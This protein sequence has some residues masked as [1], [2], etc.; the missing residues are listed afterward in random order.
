MVR[1]VASLAAAASAEQSTISAE[2][3]AR[4]IRHRGDVAAGAGGGLDGIGGALR[5]VPVA[6]AEIGG[7]DADFLAGGLERDG[8]LVDGRAKA[9]GEETAVGMAQPRLRLAAF[10]V[11]RQ[12]IGVDQRLPHGFRGDRAVGERA[13]A[14]FASGSAA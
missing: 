13:A 9:L 1:S 3:A 5:H 8:E 2:Q 6:G 11:D 14:E 10:L 4:R 7:G 12:R